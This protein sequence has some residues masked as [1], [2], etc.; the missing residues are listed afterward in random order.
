MWLIPMGASAALSTGVELIK[1]SKQEEQKKKDL[2]RNAMIYKY[3]PWTGFQPRSVQKI[4]ADP[5]KGFITGAAR[6]AQISQNLDLFKG[7]RAPAATETP[8]EPSGFEITDEMIAARQ[9]SPYIYPQ[10]VMAG[11]S[12]RIPGRY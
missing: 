9:P 7:G 1:K 8:T 3:S 5:L 10:P 4:T 12:R 2:L 6:G 11:H